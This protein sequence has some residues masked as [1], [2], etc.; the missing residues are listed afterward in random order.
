M[1]C[2]GVVNRALA[3]T[4]AALVWLTALAP[5]QGTERPLVTTGVRYVNGSVGNEASS[6][7]NIGETGGAY[8]L[9]LVFVEGHK[10]ADATGVQL[11]IRDAQGRVVLNLPDAGP[12]TDIH[13]PDGHY[14]LNCQRGQTTR[15]DVVDLK[16]GQP[17]NLY[18][19][20]PRN[21]RPP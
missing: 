10:H 18:L 9:R 8:N 17:L 3:A 12:M 4:A 21:K 7:S 5:A 13:L 20:F 11:S 15:Q 16:D 14:E 19:H 6:H 2:S 1:S